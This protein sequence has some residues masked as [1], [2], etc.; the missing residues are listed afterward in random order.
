MK[1]W[2][3][4]SEVT[5]I[6]KTYS[7]QKDEF[8]PWGSQENV[9]M[10]SIIKGYM[11]TIEEEKIMV[12]GDT[13]RKTGRIIVSHTQQNGRK[14]Y[15]DIWERDKENKLQFCF[16]NLWNQ[17]SIDIDYLKDLEKENEELKRAGRKLQEENARLKKQIQA[18]KS[19]N[20]DLKRDY[21]HNARGAGR[22]PSEGRKRSIEQLRSLLDE[23]RSMDEIMEIMGISQ[24][25]YYRYKNEI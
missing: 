12:E 3:L 23:G 10:S 16:R 24:A 2:I 13:D 15:Q 19:E 1:K 8:K 25:T 22:K 18:Y 20:I 6:L 7:I 11:I 9:Y 17:P 14:T 21:K 5:K 4:K